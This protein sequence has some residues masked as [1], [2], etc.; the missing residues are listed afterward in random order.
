[1]TRLFNIAWKSGIVPKEWQT[2]VVVPLFKKRDQRVCANYR[3]ITLLS[4][5]GKVYSKVLERRVRLIV[6]PRI[7]EGQC[8][9]HPGRGTMDQLFT[10]SRIMERAWEYAHPVYMCF[11]D[12]EKA[13]DR[14]LREKLWEVLQEY[15]VKGSLL[16]A[17]QSLC[18][19]S[20]SCVRVLGSKSKAFPAGVGL[21]QGCALSPILFVVFM[22][23]ISRRSRGEE[24]L[25]FGRL[26]ISSLVFADNVVLMGSSV[27]DRQLS[28]E[29][30]AVECEAVG[31]RMMWS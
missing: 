21:R 16:G 24:G 13:Y 7:K 8:G 1:M 18:A 31:M 29:R 12:L 5:P 27:C 22:D 14:V 10:L 6:K 9:F 4:L 25:Q 3:G 20:E 26:R 19:Q 11:V 30:F 23:R 28:L 2:G 17:I 15:E